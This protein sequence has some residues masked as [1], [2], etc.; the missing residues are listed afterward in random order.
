MSSAA[1]L[2][3][4][5]RL[6]TRATPAAWL[7][8][9]CGAAQAAGP[10]LAIVNANIITID[11]TQPRAQA[12]LI[13]DGRFAVVG[14]NEAIRAQAGTSIS[15]WDLAGCTLLP[16]F[17][18]SH[19]HP[20]PEYGADSPF[21]TIA[22]GPEVVADMSELIA[23]L[24][25]RARATPKGTTIVGRGYQDTK[26]GRHP[27]RHDLDQAS[28][29]HPILITHSSGHVSV[30]NSRALEMAGITRA[31]VDPAGGAFDREADGTP[32][33][34]LRETARR[35][36]D[37]KVPPAPAPGFGEQ[38]QALLRTY[39]RYAS[40]GITSIAVAGGSADNFRLIQAAKAA[41]NPVRTYFM[42]QESA[43]AQIQ[44]AGLMAGLGDDR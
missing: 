33:G 32:N 10:D 14:S 24:R 42:H 43:L 36:L 21:E 6:L 23:A 19:L 44:A 1:R 12:A 35:G 27:N 13:R 30:A 25:N 38:V 22:L 29:D 28:M 16:G 39:N 15:I 37:G 5:V 40:H 20:R 7:V 17:I 34:V 26:L 31:T 4:C 2:H 8:L 3:S 18:D 41:G 11:P 9:M